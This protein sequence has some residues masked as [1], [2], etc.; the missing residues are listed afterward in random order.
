MGWSLGVG[1]GCDCWGRLTK[2]RV[3]GGSALVS[4]EGLVSVHF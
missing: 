3:R 2:G 4:V 1:D